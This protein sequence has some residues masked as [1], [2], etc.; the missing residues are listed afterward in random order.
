MCPDTQAHAQ[1]PRP[2]PAEGCRDAGEPS[3]EERARTVRAMFSAIA[4]TYD[5][6]NRLLSFGVDEAWRRALAS[7]LPP[8]SPHVLDV[9]C[10]TGDVTLAALRARPGA[11][12][13]GADFS[14][15]M[16]RGAVP[17]LLRAGVQDRVTLQ[18][19]SAE[20]LPYRDGVFDAVTIAFGIRNVIRRE[21][22]LGEFFRVLKPGGRALIL[23]FSLPPNPL[24]RAGYGFYFHRILPFVGGL[25]SGNVGAYRYLPRSV[26]AFPPRREFC[27]LLE[28]QGFA[29][30]TFEDFTLGVATLYQGFKP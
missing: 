26:A 15:P 27:R 16:L 7:R 13:R 2:C 6:L 30:A 11:Q 5:L 8:G 14:L 25:V 21:R 1:P 23:D 10:G 17:K 12:V 24:V 19:A 22:A 28:D 3:P 9:A 29:P 18:N 4:P 20:D